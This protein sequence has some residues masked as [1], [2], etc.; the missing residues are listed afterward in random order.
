[1][2]HFEGG[3]LEEAFHELAPST[4]N[5]IERTLLNPDDLENDKIL[6]RSGKYN[7]KLGVLEEHYEIMEHA[8]IRALKVKMGDEWNT[9]LEAAWRE[10][11][12]VAT[13]KMK[14]GN[15]E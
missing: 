2:D 3:E 14:L 4:L 9:D 11:Y 8:L 7:K 15:Y 1:M 5:A 12:E 10:A 13:H 6:H